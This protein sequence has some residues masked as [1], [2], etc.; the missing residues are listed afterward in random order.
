M[1]ESTLLAQGQ[2]TRRPALLAE[3]EHFSPAQTW[4]IACFA[5]KGRFSLPLGLRIASLVEQVHINL[6][7]VWHTPPIARFAAR[8]ST[9]LDQGWLVASTAAAALLESF[10]Q[11]WAQLLPRFVPAREKAC[12]IRPAAFLKSEWG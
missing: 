4:Q 10:R 2:Q 3:Q 8:E 1:R 5:H 9:S 12:C 6:E 7:T 11:G